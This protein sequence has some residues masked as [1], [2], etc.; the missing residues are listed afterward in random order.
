MSIFSRRTFST[1]AFASISAVALCTSA[2]CAKDK[3][4]A[5]GDKAPDFKLSTADG[6]EVSLAKLVKQGPVVLIVLRGYPGYQCPACNQQTGQFL[7]AAKKFAAAK[8]NIVLVYPGAADG[9]KQHAD[10]FTRGKTFPDNCYLALD[11]D[12]TFTNAYRLRW[13]APKETAY[14]ATFVIDQN[15]QVV[16]AKISST[17]GGRTSADEVLKAVPTK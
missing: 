14:P 7:G 4:P 17:H 11:P 12:Y 9:L 10:D 13:D 5:V 16:Y 1:L 6:E 15:Q 2:A 3:A 8:A